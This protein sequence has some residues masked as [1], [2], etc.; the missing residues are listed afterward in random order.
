MH[1]LSDTATLDSQ[2]VRKTRFG[3]LV[4]DVLAGR[5]GIQIYAGREVGRPDLPTVRVYR[6]PAEVFDKTEAM[7]S[8]TA[9]PVTLDH[10]PELVT[11]QNWSKFARGSTGEDVARDGE[12]IRVPLI[13]QDQVAIDAVEAGHREL[14]FGYTCDLDFSAGQTPDGQAYDAVQRNLRGNHLAIVGVAR[15][16]SQCR[17]GDNASQP[18]CGATPMPDTAQFRTVTVDGI[19]VTTTDAGAAVIETLQKRIGDHVTA[20]L[21]LTADNETALNVLK[22]EIALLKTT[23]AER[24]KELGSLKGELEATKAKATDT[25]ALDALVAERTDLLTKTKAIVGDLDLAGKSA[26]DI[27]RTVVAKK[28]G[29]AEV[30]DRSD[31]YVHALFDSL[32]KQA[33]ASG[34]DPVRAAMVAGTAGSSSS[35]LSARDAHKQMLKDNADAWK[36]PFGQRH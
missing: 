16:G 14:S 13:L 5:T 18:S 9:L 24:D 7:R 35:A 30:K 29:D 11:A 21:K 32:A 3:Y 8:F 23:V 22:G 31:D 34:V 6:P 33:P 12:F 25:Q 17:I 19:P 27:R 20:N 28:L 2:R 26:A 1:Q 4:A 15:A 10:P 36:M